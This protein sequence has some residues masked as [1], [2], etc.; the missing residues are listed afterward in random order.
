MTYIQAK[1]GMREQM[2][3]FLVANWF[4][5]DEI[6]VKQGLMTS[7]RLLDTGQDAAGD[8]EAW[9]IIV[10]SSYRDEKGYEGI[11]TEFEALRKTHQKVLIDGL[12]FRELGRIVKSQ[13][14]WE[15]AKVGA[16]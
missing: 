14:L 1:A 2:K 16:K 3:R 8:A 6:A 12:D 10:I 5:L 15:S 4:A 13:P 9:N 11:K 7:Y